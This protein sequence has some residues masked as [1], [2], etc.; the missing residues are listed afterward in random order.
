MFRLTGMDSHATPIFYQIH[1][2]GTT[3]VSPSSC[4][5]SRASPPPGICRWSWDRAQFVVR[6]LVFAL[7]DPNAMV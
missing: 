7:D 3:T 5:C 1:L 6:E 2:P 4:L